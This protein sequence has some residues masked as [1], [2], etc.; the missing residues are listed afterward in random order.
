M[1]YISGFGGPLAVAGAGLG[2]HSLSGTFPI[3]QEASGMR[4]LQQ[5][6]QRLGY[7]QGG[8][9]VYGADGKFG[10]R[11]A[12]ALRGAASYVGWTGA[13]YSPSN[14]GE[15]RSGEVTVPDDLIDRI[16]AARPNPSAP[17]A[18]GGPPVA[19]DAPVAPEPAVTIGPHLDPD[20]PASSESD[21]SWVLPVAIAG[22]VLVVGGAI[23][24]QMGK[25]KPRRRSR[26]TANR[27][28]RRRRRTSRRR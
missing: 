25:R 1:T 14:A 10:P 12:T 28:R 26:V 9:G 4:D 16:R 6:L 21:S 2:Y 8:A 7:L 11:T 3:R 17:Y 15:M 22:G 19:P 24:W 23:A 13:A 20:T 27:R 18:N 5:Q